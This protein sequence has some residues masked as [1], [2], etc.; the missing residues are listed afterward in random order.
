V[1]SSGVISTGACSALFSQVLVALARPIPRSASHLGL[2][3]MSTPRR[4][5]TIATGIKDSVVPI[6]QA[7][8]IGVP[9]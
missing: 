2:A 8:R 4:R 1:T 7:A 3:A 6:T 5:S 9:R